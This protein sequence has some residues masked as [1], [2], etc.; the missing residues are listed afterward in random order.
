MRLPLI[1]PADLTPEQ[2]PL[3]N[4]MKRSIETSFT[5]FKGVRHD[6]ALIGPWNPWLHF[7]KHGE[8]MW[9]LVKE[10]YVTA[11]LDKRVREVAILVSGTHF[12]AA[13]ALYAHVLM[14]EHRGFDDDT[15]ATIAAGQRSS[16]LSDAESVAYDAASAL[17][18]GSVLP[19]PVY[20]R[21]VKHFGQ[22]G[23][24]ELFYFVGLYSM[25]SITLNGFDVPAP[26]TVD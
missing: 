19:E 23:T 11:T 4:D 7:F 12:H 2:K 9:N 14:A 17:L 18:R 5:G 16:S 15:I 26:E 22:E 8:P 6:G 10:M 25:I 24:A 21:A 1:K 20:K 13:Y 3:Y